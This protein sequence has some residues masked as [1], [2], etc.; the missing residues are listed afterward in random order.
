MLLHGMREVPA[1]SERAFAPYL[2]AI[3]GTRTQNLLTVRTAELM[4]RG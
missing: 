1:D 3:D 2:C 4:V